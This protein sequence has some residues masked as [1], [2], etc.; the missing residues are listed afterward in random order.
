[1]QRSTVPNEQQSA[2]IYEDTN[3]EH[4]HATKNCS[5]GRISGRSSVRHPHRVA[6][7]RNIAANEGNRATA[8]SATRMGIYIKYVVNAFAESDGESTLPRN[9]PFT[10]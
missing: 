3:L 7:T 8:A 6:S 5:D 2:H 10:A 9:L 4:E 1:V